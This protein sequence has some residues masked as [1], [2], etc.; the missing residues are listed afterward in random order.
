MDK[1]RRGLSFANQSQKTRLSQLS[2]ISTFLRLNQTKVYFESTFR[3]F[4]E[5]QHQPKKL[6]N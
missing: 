6:Q 3:Y 1:V 5:F 4:D 2:Q